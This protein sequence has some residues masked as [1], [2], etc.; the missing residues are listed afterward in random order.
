MGIPGRI[1]RIYHNIW[2]PGLAIISI[3]CT[4]RVVKKPEDPLNTDEG[5]DLS[6]ELN[7]SQKYPGCQLGLMAAGAVL[8]FTLK[9]KQAK[10]EPAPKN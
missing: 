7:K 9:P 2:D 10:T 3:S 6:M 5:Q 8:A 1:N 4:M